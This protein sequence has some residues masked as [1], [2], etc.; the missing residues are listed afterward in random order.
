MLAIRNY[1]GD[2]VPQCGPALNIQQGDIIELTRADLHSSWWQV[3]TV[4]VTKYPHLT[5]TS[6]NISNSDVS[7]ILFLI[8]IICYLRN[9][10]LTQT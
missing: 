10:L 4:K 6:S 9:I 8:K 1:H 2:P 7:V 5:F 3:R